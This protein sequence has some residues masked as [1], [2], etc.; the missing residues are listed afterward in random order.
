MVFIFVAGA[1]VLFVLLPSLIWYGWTTWIVAFV[2]GAFLNG[3]LG[4]EVVGWFKRPA[5][6]PSD[7]YGGE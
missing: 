5:D 1:N 7:E 4:C 2:V 3:L 6:M